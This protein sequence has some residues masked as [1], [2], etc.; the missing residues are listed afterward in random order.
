MVL[1]PEVS[2]MSLQ[3]LSAQSDL[4]ARITGQATSTSSTAKKAAD[5]MARKTAKDAKIMGDLT[6]KLSIERTMES[7]RKGGF[8]LMD[9]ANAQRRQRAQS[10]QRTQRANQRG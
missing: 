7:R 8:L 9:L 10:A 2:Q 3:S 4:I 5:A 6:K 1:A